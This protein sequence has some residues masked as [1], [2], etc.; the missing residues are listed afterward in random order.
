MTWVFNSKPLSKTEVGFYIGEVKIAEI[1]MDKRATKWHFYLRLMWNHVTYNIP[2][3]RYETFSDALTDLH[4]RLNAPPP[5]D[6]NVGKIF[7]KEKVGQ[8]E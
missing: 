1:C 2:A 6:H 3:Q 7:P 5:E 4:R 8:D